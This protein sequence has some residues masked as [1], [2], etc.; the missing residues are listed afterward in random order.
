MDGVGGARV[1]DVGCW[2]WWRLVAVVLLFPLGAVISIINTVR[3][4]AH[5]LIGWCCALFCLVFLPMHVVGVTQKC[6]SSFAPNIRQPF[7][8]PENGV[9]HSLPTLPHGV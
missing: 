8:S 2:C 4:P 5:L 1:T 3:R 6:G 9:E 7:F